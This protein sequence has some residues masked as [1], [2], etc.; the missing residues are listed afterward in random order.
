VIRLIS[1]IF[2]GQST[3]SQATILAACIWTRWFLWS[4]AATD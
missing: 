2:V 3:D 4:L 1:L